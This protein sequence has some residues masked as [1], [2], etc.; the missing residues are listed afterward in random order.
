MTQVILTHKNGTQ[1]VYESTPHYDKDKKQSRPIRKLIGKI[2]PETGN[3][4]PTGKRGR[5]RKQSPNDSAPQTVSTIKSY[6]A[7]YLLQQLASQTGI[8]ADLKATFPQD[9]LTILSLAMFLTLEPSNALRKYERWCDKT[10]T[11]TEQALTSQRI[12]DL[13]SNLTEESIQQFFHRQQKRFKQEEF[14]VFDTTSVSTYSAIDY[15][16]FGYNKEQDTLKQINL[17]LVVSE[18]SR[19]PVMYR[20]IPGNIVD[21][22]TINV[23]LR[24]LDD[25]PQK[26][27]KLVLDRGFY[28][29]RNILQL[30]QEQVE[31]IIGGKKGISYLDKVIEELLPDV[32]KPCNYHHELKMYMSSK[33]ISD[34]KASSTSHYPVTVHVYHSKKLQSKE[35]ERYM[36]ELHEVLTLLNQE[37]YH[38]DDI[39]KTKRGYLKHLIY[40]EQTQQYHIN[41]ETLEEHMSGFGTFVLISNTTRDAA[42][43]LRLYRDKDV[44]EKKF[45]A[46][47]SELGMRR[48]RTHTQSATEGKLFVQYISL[49]LESY[50]REGMRKSGLADD[51]TMDDLLTEV[52]G[53]YTYVNNQKEYTIAEVTQVQET[54]FEKLNIIHPHLSIR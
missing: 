22:K 47:K 23:L 29:Q 14:W 21:S 45:E 7:T 53:I 20:M 18:S 24:L 44:V 1:Y 10:D 33:R 42:S 35:E 17:G 16:K 5:P 54:I 8:L 36:D 9:Y 46:Y 30:C 34:F 37:G 4:V 52:K 50:L 19:I 38:A 27:R 41:Y 40:D 25:F 48:L 43:C 49:L 3:I 11:I 26:R 6:G 12:S 39:V 13:L 2:D 51:Y 15:A 31:F 32:K 28:S